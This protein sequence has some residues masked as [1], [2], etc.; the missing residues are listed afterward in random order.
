MC[1]ELEGWI[2]DGVEELGFG[3]FF[4]VTEDFVD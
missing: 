3:R 1:F 2:N 4:G